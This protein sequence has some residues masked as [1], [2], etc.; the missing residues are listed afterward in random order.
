VEREGFTDASMS[1]VLL[2]MKPPCDHENI[3][4]LIV[5][6]TALHPDGAAEP[7]FRVPVKGA[8][9]PR[10]S[11]FSM[12]NYLRQ[13]SGDHLPVSPLRTPGVSPGVKALLAR[14][15][16]GAKTLN[17]NKLIFCKCHGRQPVGIYFLRWV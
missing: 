7:F 2:P 5:F 4:P 1:K 9:F 10:V 14:E 16:E 8:A 13:C 3:E 11:L 12:S 15:F 6:W 17:Q